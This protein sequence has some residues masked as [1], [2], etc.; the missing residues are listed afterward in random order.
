MMKIIY[1]ML[2][3]SLFIP[4]VTIFDR[5]PSVYPNLFGILYTYELIKF[6]RYISKK[7]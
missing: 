3:A 5:T 2:L 6:I 4:C 7:K 1:I